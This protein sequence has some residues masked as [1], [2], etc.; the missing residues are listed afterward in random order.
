MGL[1]PTPRDES[2][3]LR[4]IDSKRVTRDFRRSGNDDSLSTIKK[5]H[6]FGATKHIAVAASAAAFR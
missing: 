1:R 6:F 3:L 2:A 4:R 5:A